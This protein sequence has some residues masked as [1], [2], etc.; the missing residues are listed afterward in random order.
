[1][2]KQESIFSFSSKNTCSEVRETL[3]YL[4]LTADNRATSSVNIEHSGPVSEMCISE[5][6]VTD[7][8]NPT[9][10]TQLIPFSDQCLS[11]CCDES[12]SNPYQPKINFLNSKRTQGKQM[13]VFR[14]TCFEDHKWFTYCLTRRK[15]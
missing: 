14:S 12:L 10:E 15:V 4:G 11:E 3:N 7:V 8:Y 9:H 13:R 6:S 2:S 1:M 5:E